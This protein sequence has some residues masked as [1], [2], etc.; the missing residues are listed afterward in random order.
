MLILY[1]NNM[2]NVA[3]DAGSL[4][5]PNKTTFMTTIFEVISIESHQSVDPYGAFT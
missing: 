5:G 1:R 2:E 4:K 3:V